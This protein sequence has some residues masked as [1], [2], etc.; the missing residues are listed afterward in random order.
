MTASPASNQWKGGSVQDPSKTLWVG[1]VPEGTNYTDLLEFA[2]QFGEAKWAEVYKTTAAIGF[3][4]AEVATSALA[5]LQGADFR[6]VSLVADIWTRQETTEGPRQG[7]RRGRGKGWGKGWGKA[8]YQ[9]SRIQDP[10]KT[11]WVGN[12]ALGTKYPELLELGKTAGDAKWA[13]TWRNIGAIGYATTEDAASAATKLNGT[14]LS[15]N[16][17][18]VDV[19]TRGMAKAKGTSDGEPT[20]E[21]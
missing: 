13:D 5:K 20:P 8:L 10:T 14:E 11:L 12:L 6:G 9:R 16:T 15:G 1:A 19:W 18:S 4:S 21:A 7:W 17:L 3:A 2:Q